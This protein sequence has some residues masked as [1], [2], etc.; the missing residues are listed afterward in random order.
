MKKSELT[1]LIRELL[2]DRKLTKKEKTGLKKLE[3]D[4]PKEPFKKKYGKEGE[5]IYYGTLT[6]Q[7]KKKY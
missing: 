4:I 3:K 1:E 2:S 7:A 5:S 6:K